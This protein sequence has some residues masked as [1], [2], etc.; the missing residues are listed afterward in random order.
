MRLRMVVGTLAILA[1]A[2]C[3]SDRALFRPNSGVPDGA[4]ISAAGT[5]QLRVLGADTGLTWSSQARASKGLA[6]VTEQRHPA[7]LQE[8]V[9]GLLPELVAGGAAVARNRPVVND[10]TFGDRTGHLHR[11]VTTPGPA[12]G[13]PG[14]FLLYRDG[15]LVFTTVYQW[16]Q[17]SAGWQ[18]RSAH[19]IGFYRGRV[20]ADATVSVEGLEVAT[21]GPIAGALC[22]LAT[23]LSPQPLE[24]EELRCLSK[25]L[26]LIAADAAYGLA[27]AN[28]IAEPLNPLSWV[29]YWG[30][31]AWVSGA[32]IELYD[33]LNGN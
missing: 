33:C 21:A 23:I 10:V 2:A 29:A 30:A 32:E 12:A 20:I 8:A 24:A 28:M 1:F 6:I 7:S 22:R 16:Q 13:V 14:G 26:N 31:V 3:S 27:A 18:A 15:E 19:H 17:V 25:Y 4:R 5:A 9:S 11:L